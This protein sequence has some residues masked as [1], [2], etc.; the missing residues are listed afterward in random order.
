[1]KP[2]KGTHSGEKHVSVG[3]GKSAAGAKKKAKPTP[4][5]KPVAE[6]PKTAVDRYGVG[7]ALAEDDSQAE[8][9]N[10]L[11]EDVMEEEDAG[12]RSRLKDGIATTLSEETGIPYDDVNKFVGQWAASSNDD[13]MRSLAIQ[14]DA[15][16]E[17]DVPLSD[18][19]KGKIANV[20][21]VISSSSSYQAG[22]GRETT[23]PLMPSG[24]QRELL[25]SMYENT[26]EALINAGFD[27]DGTIRLYRGVKLPTS[28]AGSWKKG[29]TIPIKSSTL[30]SWSSSVETAASFGS[31]TKVGQRGVLLQMDIP[32][33]AIMGSAISG[34][35]CLTEQEFVAL[36]TGGQARVFFLEENE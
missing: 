10:L 28:V 12:H 25:R 21:S 3:S 15:A 4:A 19:T 13:D 20:E 11:A 33:K 35:G 6:K 30:S 23:E 5:T 22:I 8:Q 31:H 26:Q 27:K 17:F 16:A 32:V 1:F 34:F 7:L 2:P 14:K 24:Q 36:G 9:T 29:D 18:F